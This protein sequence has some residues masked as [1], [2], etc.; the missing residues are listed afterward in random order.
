VSEKA[1]IRLLPQGLALEA[2]PGTPLKDLLFEHGVEFPCGGRGLCKRCKVR[3][4]DGE[5]DDIGPQLLS[6]AE[7]QQGERIACQHHVAGDATLEVQQWETPILLDESTFEFV[8]GE[9]WGVAIDLGTTTL[10]GQLLDLATGKVLAVRTALNR[11]AEFG[12]DIMSRICY[13]VSPSG[14]RRLRELI[15]SQLCQLVRDLLQA[16]HAPAVP[17]TEVVIVGNTPMH[18]I[19]CD[20]DL[21]PLSYYPFDPANDGIAIFSKAQLDWDVPG[22]P[23]ITFLP[24]L[25]GFVGSDIL[26]GLL[27]TGL[28]ERDELTVFVDLGTTGEIVIGNRER[29]LCASTAAG[30]AFEA[31]RISMGMQASTGAVTEVRPAGSNGDLA[32]TVLGGGPA[33]G[34]CGSGLVDAVAALLDTGKLTASGRFADRSQ[35]MVLVDPVTLSQQD[36]RELQ[37]AKGAIA[38]GID[39]LVQHWGATNDD[40]ALVF[41]AGAFGNYIRF[42]SAERIGLLNF[43]EDRLCASGN[44]ALLGAKLAMFKAPQARGYD[45]L[46]NR[47]EHV[48]LNTD[49]AFQ[50]QFVDALLFP[51]EPPHA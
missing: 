42:S 11:Q 49:P 14:A 47:I 22:E 27:A 16:V 34:I 25:G 6:D 26:A 28:H 32:C 31:A 20:Y 23:T 38:T 8:P 46:R 44:T 45:E 30:P 40:V 5:L 51:E 18:N 15:R 48:S 37:L 17:L 12:S 13:G 4:R 21:E 50:D 10:A 19:F 24:G 9:G 43:P 29:M 36:V 3:L 39:M 33:R 2:A 41:V 7:V 1:K 35:E